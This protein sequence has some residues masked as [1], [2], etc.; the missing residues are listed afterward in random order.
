MFNEPNSDRANHF[1]PAFDISSLSSFSRHAVRRFQEIKR[2]RHPV[3]SRWDEEHIFL[4]P[5]GV[6]VR[7]EVNRAD[8]VSRESERGLPPEQNSEDGRDQPSRAN[9]DASRPKVG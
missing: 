5:D 8:L 4:S 1:E 3:R 7:H 9:S 6:F 2:E